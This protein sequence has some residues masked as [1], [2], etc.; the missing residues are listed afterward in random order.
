MSN[1]K[2]N[3]LVASRTLFN[4]QGFSNVTIRMIAQELKIS[5]GNLNY[6]YKKREDIFEA[7]YFEM[8]SEFD[9][10][11]EDLTNIEVTIAQVRDDIESS[12]KRM[13]DYQ[14]FWTDLYNLQQ[15]SDRVSKHFQG[16]YQNRIAGCFLLFEKMQQQGLMK[17]SSFKFEYKFLA[18]RMINFGNTWLYNSSLYQKEISTDYI[19]LQSNNLLSLLYPYLT[20]LGENEYKRLVP[21]YFK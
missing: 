21:D 12:M 10:R 16:V 13:L 5:S 4:Q 2:T 8:V 17:A 19:T 11:I 20:D 3:I 15:V 9:K 1:R 14:F 18:E 6:H 7:L